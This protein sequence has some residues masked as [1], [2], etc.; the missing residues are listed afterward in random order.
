MT[1]VLFYKILN[2]ELSSLTKKEGQLIFVTDTKRLYLDKDANTRI[3]IENY[4]L[5]LDANNEH[6][7]KFTTPDGTVTSFKIGNVAIQLSEP[8]TGEEIWIKDGKNLFD[9]KKTLI[10]I[11]VSNASGT[12][13]QFVEHASYDCS[14]YV[15]VKPNTTYIR[16]NVGAQGIYFYDSSKTYL[17]R[18]SGYSFTTPNNCYY[19]AF[20]IPHTFTGGANA[21]ML[22]QG[23]TLATL[24]DYNNYS[25]NTLK[26]DGQYKEIY[27]KDN[28]GDLIVDNIIGKNLFNKTDSIETDKSYSSTGNIVTTSGSFIQ[29]SYIEVEPKTR[30]T[31]SASES[32]ILRICEYTSDKTFVTR[33]A[34]SDITKLTILTGDTTKYIRFSGIIAV[35]DTIQ[36]EKGTDVTSFTPYKTFENNP[37]H[38]VIIQTEQPTTGEGV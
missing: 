22:N 35:I 17:S 23:T 13:G 5:E 19:V 20:N 36:I 38:E 7:L 15:K 24:D 29:T 37:E 25:I 18:E 9:Y 32:T 12:E 16:T 8:T 27:N 31:L 4:Q 33:K 26:D 2:S 21:V 6:I 10:N 30:Y 3:E 14:N 1:K 11:T 34:A 28:M